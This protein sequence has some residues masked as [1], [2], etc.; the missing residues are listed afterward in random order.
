M[1]SLVYVSTVSVRVEEVCIAQSIVST[2]V[3]SVYMRVDVVSRTL[4]YDSVVTYVLRGSDSV[5]VE[6]SLV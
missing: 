1:L 2:D 5:Y 4:V 6:I 3:S